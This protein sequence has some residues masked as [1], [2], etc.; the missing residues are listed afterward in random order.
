MSRNTKFKIYYLF[1]F[2][3]W[4]GFIGLGPAY[5][6]VWQEPP[7]TLQ[8]Y[9]L[10]MINGIITGLLGVAVI[11]YWVIIGKNPSNENHLSSN[12]DNKK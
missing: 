2:L 12:G 4:V 3:F 7:T 8:A 9:G 1:M 6:S 10:G 11:Y 5:R